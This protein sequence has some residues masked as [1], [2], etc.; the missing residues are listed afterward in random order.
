MTREEMA[1]FEAH[2]D[3][4]WAWLSA[5][6]AKSAQLMRDDG[7]P[8]DEVEYFHKCDGGPQ[9]RESLAR[10][11]W[12]MHLEFLATGD[13]RDTTIRGDADAAALH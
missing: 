11:L 6:R 7:Y 3:R 12:A 8:E 1:R 4:C 2:V 9:T 13:I 10:Q 5:T